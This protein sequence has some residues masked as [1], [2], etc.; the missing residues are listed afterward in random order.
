VALLSIAGPWP[1]PQALPQAFSGAGWQQVVASLGTLGFTAALAAGATAAALA[2]TAAWLEAT[3]AHWDR[4][5]AVFVLAPL[6]LPPLLLMAGLY[7][8]ALH[9]GLDGHVAGLLWGHALVVLPYAFIVL[10][11]AWRDLDPRWRHTALALGRS[12]WA[13]RW[14]VQRPLLAAPLAAAAAVGFAV[15]VGQFL[16][17]QMLGAGRHPTVA[18]EAVTLASGGD[19]RMAAA[20]ALLQALLPMLAFA[21]ARRWR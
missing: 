16:A 6:V 17:T 2:L 8:G 3:P 11:P 1:F 14:Q 10:Q 18:T 4:R 19:R 13:F 9:L 12:R 21:A 20:Y 15:S 7:H 5:V